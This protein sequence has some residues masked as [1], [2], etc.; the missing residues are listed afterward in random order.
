M[1]AEV[2]KQAFPLQW[3]ASMGGSLIL[4]EKSLLI[5]WNGDTN[6][7]VRNDEQ[8]VTDYDRA[9]DVDDYI[10]IIQVGE[11]Q[12]IVLGDEPM[13]TA[14][15]QVGEDEGILA[16]WM[17]ANSEETVIES[18]SILENVKWENTEL[19]ILFQH[20]D[21]ILFDSACRYD[22]IEE[23]LSLRIKPN[24]YKIETALYQPNEETSLVLHRFVTKLS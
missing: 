2:F 19:E 21:L 22:E 5:N 15:W 17:Y 24:Q 6:P 9:C 18:L 20:G 3:I 13:Q 14:W 11:S 23:S 7:S 4:M 16:R 8:G 10:G 1:S 12:A